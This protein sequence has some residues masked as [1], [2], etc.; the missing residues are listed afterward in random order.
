MGLL[1]CASCRRAEPSSDAGAPQISSA[2][3][4]S[5][6]A[7]S[8]PPSASIPPAPKPPLQLL[9][10]R[11]TTAVHG[12][13]PVDELLAIAPSERVYAHVALRNRSGETRKVKMVFRVA[14]VDRTSLDLDVQSSWSY[15]TWGYNTVREGDKGDVEVTIVDD[16]GAT[17]VDEKIP[18]AKKTKTK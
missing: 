3:P 2:E 12:K 8:P 5:A 17:L 1:A 9:R 16:T 7:S 14:G 11:F 4:P 15:R 13:E 10:F 18:I 6:S